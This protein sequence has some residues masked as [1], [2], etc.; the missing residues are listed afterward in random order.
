METPI[1]RGPTTRSLGDLRS[2]WLL[3]IYIHSKKVTTHPDIA[4]PLGNPRQSM[5]INHL[6]TMVINHLLTMVINHL[7]TRMILQLGVLR[8]KPTWWTPKVTRMRPTRRRRHTA[9]HRKPKIGTGGNGG[10]RLT[11][12]VA[13]KHLQSGANK[14]SCRVK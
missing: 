1:G 8:L 11:W 14:T 2:P 10:V 7:L 6:L 9:R 5:V 12:G 4:H 3:T 13:G